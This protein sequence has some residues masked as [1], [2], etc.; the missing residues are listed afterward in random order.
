LLG[1]VPLSST[2][3]SIALHLPLSDVLLVIFQAIYCPTAFHDWSNGSY[4]TFFT[5]SPREA[6]L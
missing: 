6:M 4:P 1:I 2:V 3:L 5:S